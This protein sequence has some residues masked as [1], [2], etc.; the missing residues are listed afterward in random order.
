MTISVD[1]A[2]QEDSTLGPIEPKVYTKDEWQQEWTLNPYLTCQRVTFS[3]GEKDSMAVLR[4][5]FGNMIPAGFSAFMGVA[6]NNLV[7]SF[8]KVEFTPHNSTAR[9]FIGVIVA[10]QTETSG[11]SSTQHYGDFSYVAYG[12]EWFLR[13]YQVVQ[14]ISSDDGAS[15][16][17]V[18]SGLT[19]NAGGGNSGDERRTTVGN[20]RTVGDGPPLFSEDEDGTNEWDAF[21][22]IRYLERYHQPW[23]TSALTWG[24]NPANEFELEWFTPKNV[25]THGRTLRDIINQVIDK[26]R[27]L[28]HSYSVVADELRL[29][30]H[31][32][33]SDDIGLPSG[34]TAIANS[35]CIALTLNSRRRT[36]VIEWLDHSNK[37]EQVIVQGARKTRTLTLQANASPNGSYCLK[38]D[39]TPDEEASYFTAATGATGYADMSRSEKEIANEAYWM[40]Y[41]VRR[42]FTHFKLTSSAPWQRGLQLSLTTPMI[43][44]VDYS[45]SIPDAST[46]PAG[47]YQSSLAFINFGSRYLPINDIAGASTRSEEIDR[48]GVKFHVHVQEYENKRGV[49]IAPTCPAHAIAFS[50]A[51]FGG[52]LPQYSPDSTPICDYKAAYITCTIEEND[53]LTVRYPSVPDDAIN[54]CA[55]K[56]VISLGDDVRKDIIQSGTAIG[57]DNNGV[58]ITTAQGGSLRD[59]EEF[60]QDVAR[61]AYEWYKVERQAIRFEINHINGQ[62]YAGDLIVSVQYNELLTASPVNTIVSSITYDF[63]T[64]QT[65]INTDLAEELDFR[66]LA[67]K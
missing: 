28:T 12:L 2:Y 62:L 67:A 3:T 49:I 66:A 33:F 18:P 9:E 52:D 61:M 23:G 11:T 24:I 48:N 22:I 13:R 65:S 35:R 31:P 41:P 14:S 21:S 51:F 45:G 55:S 7:R 64:Q 43:Q 46:V 60:C 6:R 59:D 8:V 40:T 1:I 63:D 20:M 30:V 37:Y 27:G 32:Y 42:V 16:N 36:P 39:W 5:H 47:E 34:K 15:H 26:R 50:D 19:F 56:Q 4:S 10:S 25:P 29:T 57:V 53:R 17:A 58:L 44:G 38:A 54:N